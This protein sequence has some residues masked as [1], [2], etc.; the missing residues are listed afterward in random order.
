MESTIASPAPI[1]KERLI[2]NILMKSAR[3]VSRHIMTSN[4]PAPLA[5]AAPLAAVLPLAAVVPLRLGMTVGQGREFG[6][7]VHRLAIPLD[8]ERQP[9]SWCLLLNNPDQLGRVL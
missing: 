6:D 1:T 7:D 2:E 3:Y 4:W 8:R 5:V 9:G